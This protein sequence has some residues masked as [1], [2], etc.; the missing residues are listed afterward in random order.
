MTLRSSD[1]DTKTSQLDRQPMQRLRFHRLPRSRYQYAGWW[2][3]LPWQR[4][5]E[6]RTAQS[7]QILHMIGAFD[8]PRL[9]CQQLQHRAKQ[10]RQNRAWTAPGL[11]C[12]SQR[13]KNF[14][15]T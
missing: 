12:F 14:D 8:A 3:M 4:G 6:M 15:D 11:Q 1:V 13:I 10:H 7:K 9:T 5:G 2:R